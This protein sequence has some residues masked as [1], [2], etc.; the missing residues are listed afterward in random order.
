MSTALEIT[1][2]VAGAIVYTNITRIVGNRYR[3]YEEYSMWS[4]YN[5]WAQLV[6]MFWPVMVVF[7]PSTLIMNGSIGRY[8][9]ARKKRR[10][11]VDLD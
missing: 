4:Q 9:K 11:L 1:L 3:R 10:K 7:Y 6:G 2:W 8:F 5:N